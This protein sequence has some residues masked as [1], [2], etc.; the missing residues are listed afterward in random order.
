MTSAIVALP[1]SASICSAVGWRLGCPTGK[2]ARE[3]ASPARKPVS[4]CCCRTAPCSCTLSFANSCS[5]N[6]GVRSCSAI[7][8][9]QQGQVLAQ[10][11]APDLQ[12]AGIH[13]E[14]E[15]CP[16][17]AQFL[18]NGELVLRRRA[19]VEHRAGERGQHDVAGRAA[20][21]AGRQRADEGHDV[22]NAGGQRN[23][24]DAV[25]VG[26]DRVS[27]D[28]SMRDGGQQ[29]RGACNEC[30]NESHVGNSHGGAAVHFAAAA[31][32]GVTGMNQPVVLLFT[33]RYLFAT[34]LMSAAV[35]FAVAS[36][37]V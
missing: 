14:R 27:C 35:T 10:A 17:V 20:V 24:V 19:L 37:T 11:S 15:R 36:S 32:S 6:A 8:D 21:V 1:M 7:R 13:R 26:A 16:D 23:H 22:P 33:S 5:E 3:N 18:G 30:S 31:A 9:Y 29:E 28:G 34:R 12:R 2:T 4:S 25:D